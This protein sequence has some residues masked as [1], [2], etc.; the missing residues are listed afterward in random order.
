[1]PTQA[2]A[3]ST[4][5]EE[6]RRQIAEIRRDT[7][8]LLA[9]VSDAQ[10]NWRPEP[11]RWSVAECLGHLNVT[12]TAYLRALDRAISEARS[13]GLTGGGAFRSGLLGGWM[14]RSMEP[15]PRMK[16]KA[17]KSILPPAPDRPLATVREEFMALQDEME[18]RL[19]DAEGLDLTRARVTSP[20]ASFLRVRLGDAFGFLLAHERRHLW[21]ARRVRD[22]PGFAQQR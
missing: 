18:R 5:L 20:V 17:P 4:T 16:M 2:I 12:G 6:Y 14:T 9:G 19:R 3:P 10:F 22:E 8:E 11:H 15:P 7:D 13:R 21:Q 1:M